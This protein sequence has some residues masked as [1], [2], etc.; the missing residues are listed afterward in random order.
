MPAESFDVP[1]ALRRGGKLDDVETSVEYTLKLIQLMCRKLALPDLSRSHVLDMGCGWRMAKTLLDHDIPIAQYTGMDVFA[2]MIE[3][4]QATISDPRFS[5][6]V[7]DSH[8]EMYN[9]S[10]RPLAELS[11]LGVPKG[12][13]DI[14]CLFSVF[15][16]LAPHDYVA[17]LKLLR[18]YIRPDG[19]LMFSLFVNETTSTGRGFIDSVSRN[20][21]N[22]AAR[23][24][25]HNDSFANHFDKHGPPAFVDFDPSQPLK[26]A[27]YSREHAIELVE[28]TGWKIESLND[29]EE[30]IQHYM[31]CTPA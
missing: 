17:M 12:S 8:N 2:E 26:W 23:F 20:W 19:K 21:A 5:F 3:F 16:H 6:H 15:T 31:I 29:P 4:L 25:E 22:N 28:G 13:F 11:D 1:R 7:L 10:G 30:A 14:I 9:P 27:I 18:S 24:K